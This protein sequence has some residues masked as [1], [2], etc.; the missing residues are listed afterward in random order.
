MRIDRIALLLFVG[1]SLAAAQQPTV[2]RLDKPAASHPA[3]WSDVAGVY[4]LGNGKLVVLDA[5]DRAIKL[6]DMTTGT[7]TMIGR[8]GS[9]PGEYEL[10]VHIFGLPGD[11]AIVV[12]IA[13][14][15]RPL[16]INSQGGISSYTLKIPP[17]P[18]IS[19]ESVVDARGRVYRTGMGYADLGATGFAGPAIERLDRRTG[20]ID[21]VGYVSRNANGCAF[22]AAPSR[23]ASSP[24][25]VEGRGAGK[26]HAYSAL[27]QWAV[28]PDG[29]VAIVCPEPYRVLLIDSAGRRIEGPVIAYDRVRIT[30]REKADWREARQQP[31]ATMMINSNRQVVGSYE[32]QPPPREPD[33]PEFLPAFQ[34]PRGLNG[35]AI[36][37]PDGLLWVKR[38]VASGAPAL[39]DIIGRNGAL[40]YRITLPPRTRVVG[41]GNRGIYAVTFDVDDVQRLGRFTFP[42]M[43]NR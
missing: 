34:A 24:I 43:D 15:G 10:P 23:G 22:S 39:Y 32:R 29:R 5:R 28:S 11:S 40:Q 8:R 9:G 1:P 25:S 17:T 38:M 14:N 30:D 12:D 36:F 19:E 7:A 13:N 33:W 4:E 31:V 18:F 20:R 41:F 16:V 35:A 2:I 21:T 26:R 42:P 3:E 6:A 37:A 27:E